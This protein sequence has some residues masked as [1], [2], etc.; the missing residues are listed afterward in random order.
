MDYSEIL[1]RE[2]SEIVER[3]KDRRLLRVLIKKGNLVQRV[4]FKKEYSFLKLSFIRIMCYTFTLMKNMIYEESSCFIDCI[5]Y[6][7]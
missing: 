4:I 3:E 5:V 6:F 7:Y 1:L 2:K